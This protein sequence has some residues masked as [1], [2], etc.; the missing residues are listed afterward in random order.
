MSGK[1]SEKDTG[2]VVLAS[3]GLF[4]FQS[5]DPVEGIAGEEAEESAR[6]D[7]EEQSPYTPEQVAVGTVTGR[8]R[9]RRGIRVRARLVA[10]SASGPV[11]AAGLF[12]LFSAGQGNREPSRKSKPEAEGLFCF[13]IEAGR[14]RPISSA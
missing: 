2:G 9:A 14:F 13:L 11:P 10:R 4:V 5:F 7:F 12:S 1:E 6:L 8:G 3:P